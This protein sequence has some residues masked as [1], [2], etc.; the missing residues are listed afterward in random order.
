MEKKG[1]DRCLKSA[2]E[3]TRR[4]PERARHRKRARE[5]PRYH[6]RIFLRFLTGVFP[7]VFGEKGEDTWLQSAKEST[8][9]RPESARGYRESQKVPRK[10]QRVP[11][12]Q[13]E[14]LKG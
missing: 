13:D 1:E 6:P 14:N 7:E 3:S 5:R 2:R 9:R 11:V 10:C 4:R 8:N 12:D